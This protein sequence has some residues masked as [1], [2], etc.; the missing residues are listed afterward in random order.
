[1]S[2]FYIEI[3]KRQVSDILY[4]VKSLEKLSQ[5]VHVNFMELVGKDHVF[6]DFPLLA[7]ESFVSRISPGDQ[8][9]PL[10][11]QVLPQIDELQDV[12]GFSSDPLDEK[13]HSPL[14]GV[15][16][17]YQDRVLLLVTDRCAINCRFCFRRCSSNE[18][19]SDWD[20]VFSYIRSDSTINEVILS[21]GDP[22]MLGMV[23]LHKIIGSLEVIGHIKTIRIHTR[24]PIVA[25]QLITSSLIRVKIATIVV[26]HCNHPNEIN[27]E[28][29]TALNLLRAQ[30][31]TIFN[32]S[33]LLKGINDD[34][35]TLRLLSEKLFGVG[36][37]PYYLHMLDRVN[38]AAH[39]WVDMERAKQI[40]LEMKENLPGY[41]VPKLVVEVQGKKLYV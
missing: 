37:I 38:G 10:L 35:A 23:E 41:L 29:A 31:I 39:F 40:Y 22:L 9:D 19:I 16:R 27:A 15:I 24:L 13:K 33:V 3:S 11:L 25:P 7:P 1:M 28:V 30:G 20:T 18:K 5:M 4:M 32:Q 8:K 6:S 2:V 17:K 21:G 26:V 14:V 34:S 36:V 12:D